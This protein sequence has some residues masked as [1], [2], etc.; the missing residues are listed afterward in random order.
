MVGKNSI[1]VGFE[2]GQLVLNPLYTGGLF[3]CY[4]LDKSSCHFR[5][6]RSILMLF[7]LFFME[8]PVSKQCRS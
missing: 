1:V 4:I 3:H 8:N 5:D 7:F 2:S 6:L